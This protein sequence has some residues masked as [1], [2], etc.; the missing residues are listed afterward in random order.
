MP[1]IHR[2]QPTPSL[3]ST[4]P[5]V[6]PTGSSLPRTD[7]FGAGVNSRQ[8]TMR[9]F[10][11]A[12]VAAAYLQVW[13]ST[14][15]NGWQ[16][17]MGMRFLGRNV[18]FFAFVVAVLIGGTWGITKLTIDRLLYRDAVS[19]GSNW[20]SYLARNIP[21]LDQ[22][23]AGEKPS[24][25]S[26]A[27]FEKAHQV[28][29]VFRYKI[30]DREGRLRLV[31]DELRAVGTDLQ[32]LGE[33]N[34]AAASS[35]AAGNPLV[36]AKEGKPPLRPPFFS[37]AYLPVVVNGKTIA[38]VE[39][40]VDQTEKLTD[41]R[42]TF[43]IAT[44]SLSLLIAFSFGAPAIAWYRR[45]KE[46]DRA[47]AHIHFL[48]YHDATTGLPNRSS[49]IEKLRRDLAELSDHEGRLALHYID[50]D[51]FKNINDTL[52]HDAGDSLIKMTAERLRATAGA[53]NFVA[54]L[55]G[56]E[57]VVV[58]IELTSRD[59][60]GEL[61]RRISDVL[62]KPHLLNGH[63][64]TATASVGVAL[65]PADGSEVAR[66]MK[67]ADLAL[68]RCKADGR[69]CIRFF[70][71]ELD[72]EL[73]A[74]LRTEKLIR[75]AVL[76]DGFKLYY[77]PV[78]D[79]K[80]YH[81]VGFEALLRLESQN[82]DFI[83]P[84]VFIPIA[85]EMGLINK[86]GAW[87]IQQA[88][89][90]AASWPDHLKIAV[91]LSPAQFAKVGIHDVVATALA[92]TS[93]QPHRLELEITEGLLLRGTDAVMAELHKLKALGIGIVMDDFGTGYSSLSY[94]WRFPFDKIKIDRS[95]MQ[96]FDADDH[97][98]A[99]TIVRAIVQLGQ[100]LHMQVTVEGVENDKQS[101]FVCDAKCD[102]IQG[103][104]FSRPMPAADVAACILADYER[105]LAHQPS[106]GN[107]KNELQFAG[108]V[109]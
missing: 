57:F 22:I 56:D 89:Q 87:V 97:N 4:K 60:A 91:N 26:M 44:L 33:H 53:S 82:G 29:Q 77:Q 9:D 17:G 45:T 70:T 80:D 96:A 78:V 30:F 35:I 8:S 54:R 92:V 32:N 15:A 104:H 63:E 69:N 50:I 46:K 14:T 81:L 68:Y 74:R 36:T 39:A 31:S 28:G 27:F 40:Y 19:T 83:S 47:D 84:M 107:T 94:L 88:C 64:I 67:S 6:G 18:A 16:R 99:E 103:F 55:S 98:N 10:N 12:A 61:A 108:R 21:D 71:P 37:E 42:D 105:S 23:A 75:D 34:P 72:S 79:A 58:Q 52:G 102:Q 2:S 86:I 76:N 90:M 62:A 100:S 25:A 73:E 85:E 109:S 59:S 49:L 5:A 13:S 51:D 7:N 3:L 101:Q 11:A 43:T 93:L 65:A 41:Y 48:A 1:L 20:A 66:L 24:A 95:F 38:I 106:V